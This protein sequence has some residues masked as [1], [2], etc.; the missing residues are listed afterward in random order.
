MEPRLMEPGLTEPGEADDTHGAPS[1]D[2]AQSRARACLAVDLP[3][4]RNPA[5]PESSNGSECTKPC[6]TMPLP[7]PLRYT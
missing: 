7:A 6:R 4:A 5:E 3:H 2:E 1:K